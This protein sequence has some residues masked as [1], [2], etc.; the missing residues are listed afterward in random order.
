MLTVGFIGAGH[1]AGALARGWA[2][3][4]A[5]D[6]PVLRFFDVVPEKAAAAASA[7]GGAACVSPVELVTA[8]DVVVLAVRPSDVATV[9][10]EIGPLLHGRGVVSVAAGVS[11]DRLRTMLP[12]D[13]RVGRVMPNLAAEL[14]LGVF[15]FVPGTLG[16]LAAELRRALDVIGSTVV[17]EESLFDVGTAISGCM[18]GFLAAI[19]EAFTAAGRVEGLEQEAACRLAVAAV[20]GAAAMVAQAGDPTAVMIATATPG[21]M[22]AAGLARLRDGRM[23]AVIKEA[24]EAAVARAKELA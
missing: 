4:S 19:V 23:A 11:L 10:T 24:V 18:P 20:R 12:A 15:L 9:L 17:V 5:P 16:D 8:S 3:S 14:G 7:C 1:I 2:A 13:A 21:G 22:T 6:A